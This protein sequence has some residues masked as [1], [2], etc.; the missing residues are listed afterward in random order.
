MGWR[1]GRYQLSVEFGQA[2]LTVVVEDENCVDHFDGRWEV[3]QS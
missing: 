3:I 1:V 2:R